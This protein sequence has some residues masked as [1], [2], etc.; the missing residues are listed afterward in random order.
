MVT[1]LSAAKARTALCLE[2]L[3]ER[4]TQL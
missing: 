3:A 4:E 1:P 2:L